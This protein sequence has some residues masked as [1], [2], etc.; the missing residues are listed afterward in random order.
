MVKLKLKELENRAA[1]AEAGI[2]IPTYDI[3]KMREA[4]KANPVWVHIGPGNLFRGFVA[5][6]ADR[7][8]EKGISERGVTVVS[9]FDQQIISK[10]YEP[11]DNLSLRVVMNTDGSLV[12][13]VVGSIA[14]VARADLDYPAEW[15]RSREIFRAPSLQMVSFTIT[16]RGYIVKDMSG[17]YLPFT[18]EAF[19]T[20]TLDKIYP[21]S[22]AILS[23]L[24][25]DRYN[26][27]AYPLTLVSM[28]NFSHNG[29][30][31]FDSVKTF[32]EKWTENG[33][34]PK[35]FLDYICGPKVSFTWSMIDKITP[36]PDETVA[37]KLAESGFEST[38]VEITDKNTYIAPFVN[39]E[40]AEYLVIEDNFPNG[41]PA[42]DKSGVYFASRET[43]DR[44]E[45]MKV[46]T[47]LNPLH[48]SM[49]IFGCMLGYESIA[50]E[51]ADPAIVKLV[52]RIGYVEGMPVVTD[53]KIFVPKKFIDEVVSER[54]PNPYIPDTP[55]RISM[56]TSLKVSIRFGETIKH[57]L[58]R[59]DLDIK[60]MEAIP[61][62]IA[63]WCRYLLALDD[64]GNAMEL[65]PD[66]ILKDVPG[67]IGSMKLGDPDSIGD[68][69]LAL[70]SNTRVFGV[71]LVALGMSDKITAY[72]KKMLVGP[73]AVRKTLDEVTSEPTF[74]PEELA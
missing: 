65:S 50:A 62:T 69:I 8:L 30:K 23:A 7:L 42:I 9:T 45:R 15:E 13:K 48:T 28:D 33:T 57:Y 61:L 29:D 27:G 24:L 59:N 25:L 72:L 32:A 49:S 18:E 21:S 74:L 2:S 36:R 71:D 64:A 41:R 52:K 10:I 11:Y 38:V 14:E 34:A 3:M 58:E 12:K 43:V 26:A 4:T 1:W 68:G 37:R 17:N 51:M 5:D 73:G 39:T 53:P 54:L 22:M 44:C 47:C 55:Q 20:P 31:L 16:E 66:P 56:N 40:K 70:L 6:L 60:N 19:K 46:C 35:G 67:Y 63:A